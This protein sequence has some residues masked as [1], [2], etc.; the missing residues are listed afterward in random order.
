MI[1]RTV[2]LINIWNESAVKNLLNLKIIVLPE[3]AGG[4]E[5]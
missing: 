1:L 4:H 3:L 2:Q 5:S